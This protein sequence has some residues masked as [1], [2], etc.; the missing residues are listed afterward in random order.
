MSCCFLTIFSISPSST[1]RSASALIS[2]LSRLAR[3][4]FR[5]AVRS[6]LPT[7]SA[8]N[9]ALVLFMTQLPGARQR[10]RERSLAPNVLGELD[11]L[12][13][14]GPLLFFGQNV[15]FFGRGKAALRA[16]RELFERREF[17]RLVDAALDR[18]LALQRAALRGDDPDHDVLVALGQEAQRLEAAGPLA[19]VFEEVAVVVALREHPFGN[20]L[21]AARRN[22]GRAEVAAADVGGDDHV[23][24]PARERLI[25]DARVVVRQRRDVHAAVLGLLHLDVRAEIGPGG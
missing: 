20:R 2:P 8:R 21:V 16:E 24:G 19:V 12:A 4:S 17:R 13:H 10:S 15:A 23:G 22:P 6:R 1:A 14:F 3:A 11:H 5:G 7:W 25:D 9:G 18:V